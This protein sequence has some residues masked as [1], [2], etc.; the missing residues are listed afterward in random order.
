M[1]SGDPSF[2]DFD[3]IVEYKFRDQD[4]FGA[5]SQ[6]MYADSVLSV[7]EADEEK[8]LDGSKTRLLMMNTQGDGS[9]R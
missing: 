3:A 1:P 6:A 9:C 5:F 2:C 4:H 7:R 8:V